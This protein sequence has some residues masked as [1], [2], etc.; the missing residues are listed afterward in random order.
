MAPSGVSQP[1]DTSWLLGL[2]CYL[3][4]TQT[5]V[6]AWTQAWSG[7]GQPHSGCIHSLGSQFRVKGRVEGRMSHSAP[8]PYSIPGT[9]QHTSP[10][11]VLTSIPLTF[12][13]GLCGADPKTPQPAPRRSRCPSALAL[14]WAVLPPSGLSLTS[15]AGCLL[16]GL[17]HSPLCSLWLQNVATWPLPS[18]SCHLPMSPWH[19]PLRGHTG[20]KTPPWSPES[21]PLCSV[22]PLPSLSPYLACSPHS[23]LI[24]TPRVLITKLSPSVPTLLSFRGSTSSS[25]NSRDLHWKDSSHFSKRPLSERKKNVSCWRLPARGPGAR[26]RLGATAIELQVPVCIAAA[27]LDRKV[28]GSRPHPGR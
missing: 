28:G 5:V 10:S 14:L 6:R 26:E 11:T 21:K 27:A 15:P 8:P 16:L 25:A 13:S 1:P 12:W 19:P 22:R 23:G 18:R 20:A 4:R 3:C 9:P 17:V 24:C 7:L 2:H